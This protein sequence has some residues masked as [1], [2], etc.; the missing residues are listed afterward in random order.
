MCVGWVMG[1]WFAGF[2]VG[3]PR[4]YWASFGS[5]DDLSGA[6]FTLEGKI[7]RWVALV[8]FGKKFIVDLVI[9]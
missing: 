4:R 7:W 3:K 2:R 6:H 1:S 8:N 9:F 5:C